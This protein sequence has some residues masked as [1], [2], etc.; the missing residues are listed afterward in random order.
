MLVDGMYS[1]QFTGVAGVGLA[2]L[3]LDRGRVYGSD[4]LVQYDGDY[5]VS[6]KAGLVDL[7]VTALVP[8]NV[9]LVQGYPKQPVA[10]QFGLKCS[11]R[12]GSSGQV[13]I[14]TDLGPV[15]AHFQYMRSLPA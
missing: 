5:H 6:S 11:L 12:P 13:L 14:Q 3:I 7:A 9:Q 4:S 8:P 10:F 15:N 1:V 2:A